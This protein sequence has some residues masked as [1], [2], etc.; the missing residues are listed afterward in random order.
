M[1]RGQIPV[2][3]AFAT[4][5]EGTAAP[6]GYTITIWSSGALLMHYRSAPRV[7]EV[8]VFIAGAVLGFTVLGGLGSSIIRRVKPLPP[9]AARAWAGMLDWFA[10]GIAAG[11]VALVA[12]IPSW[13]AWPLGSFVA[14][15]LYL[16]LASVQLALAAAGEG[17]S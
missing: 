17:E 13:V 8:F 10:V 7:W 1:T 15:L 9:G 11:A 3:R 6:Y 14:T 2:A 5:V 12:Q 4:T 16:V